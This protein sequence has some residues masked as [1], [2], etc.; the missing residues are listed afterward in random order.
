MLGPVADFVLPRKPLC[1]ELVVQVV[2]AQIASAL[3]RQHSTRHAEEPW[4]RSIGGNVFAAAP[5]DCEGLG[6]DID[7]IGA[8]CSASGVVDD[9]RQVRAVQLGELRFGLGGGYGHGPRWVATTYVSTTA[10]YVSGSGQVFFDFYPCLRRLRLT[11][12][13]TA[14]SGKQC[15]GRPEGDH[16]ASRNREV[17]RFRT[18]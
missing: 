13:E 8:R 4:Q 17:D 18:G 10:A 11:E 14:T 9:R 16:R 6:C 15:H 3:V 12:C 2:A 7:G 1:A 5:G